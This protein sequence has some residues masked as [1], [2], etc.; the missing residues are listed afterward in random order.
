MALDKPSISQTSKPPVLFYEF[1]FISA[2]FPIGESL[3][4]LGFSGSYNFED[5]VIYVKLCDCS[6]VSPTIN[7]WTPC[8]IGQCFELHVSLWAWSVW[9]DRAC[10]CVRML[11]LLAPGPY[12]PS[13]IGICSKFYSLLFLLVYE[14]V[15]QY[16]YWYMCNCTITNLLTLRY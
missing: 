12:C 15:Y 2:L 16:L 3:D 14:S 6:D 11:W 4:Y 8:V 5:Y 7:I 1:Y 9:L 10:P 13:K